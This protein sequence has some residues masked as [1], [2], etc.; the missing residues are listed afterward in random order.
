MKPVKRSVLAIS[1]IALALLAQHYLAERIYVVDAILLYAVAAYLTVRAFAGTEAIKESESVSPSIEASWPQR[2][3]TALGIACLL[4]VLSLIWLRSPAPPSWGALLWLASLVSFVLA[5][6][7]QTGT[8]TVEEQEALPWQELVVLGFVVL[9]GFL[10]RFYNL[11]FLP[12]SLHG[13]EA[14]TG[15]QAIE[16]MEGRVNDLFATGWYDL[17]MLGFAAYSVSMRVLGV[18]VFGLRMASV[19]FGTLSL[20]PF[21]FLVRS[22]FRK[23]TAVIS[24]ILLAVSH[25]YVH[26]SRLGIN[27]IQT[28]FFELL[29]FY[30]L[31]RALR[32]RKGSDFVWGGFAV[33]F[34][35]YTYYA[36]RLVP[37][38]ILMFLAYRALREKGFLRSN[39]RGIAL[40]AAAAVFAFAPLGLYFVDHGRQFASRM[41]GVFIFTA[42]NLD[43]FF[44]A[45]HTR[46]PLR[47]LWIQIVQTL[48]VF[49]YR[50]DTSGQYGFQEPILDP[51]TSAFFIL[52][53]AYSLSQWRRW[54]HFFLN[55]W[56]W[57]T[58]VTG[59]ILTTDAPFTPRLV[60]MVPVLFIFA[61]LALDR[62]REQLSQAFRP[63][64]KRYFA[65][66]TALALL[67][68][69]Y[70]NGDAYLNRYIGKQKPMSASTELARYIR[71]LGPE[72]RTYLLGAPYL[73]FGF[74]A[75]RFIARG[76]EGVDVHN[77]ADEVPIRSGVG[78]EAV[79]ILLPSHLD[80]L[81][82]IRH[83]YPSGI[84]EEHRDVYNNL[85]FT[86][87]RVSSGG[88]RG[89]QGLVGRYYRG[90]N[91]QGKPQVIRWGSMVEAGLP[92]SSSGSS[93]SYPFSVIWEGTIF[94]PRYGR[95]AWG[96]DPG[97]HACLFLDGQ[98]LAEGEGSY[99]EG[100]A[101]LPAG[102]HAIEVWSVQR[103]ADDRIALY[104][105]SPYGEKE[106]VP[107]HVLFSA[108]EIYG[109]LGS[110][111]GKGGD[112]PFLK[113]LDPIIA[114][115]SLG[116]PGSSFSVEWEGCIRIP[117]SGTYT[118]ET[119][120]WD[121]SRVYLDGQL[122]VDNEHQGRDVRA[123]GSI[124][125]DQGQ[126]DLRV[127]GE[128]LSG[129]RL[130]ELRW[131]PPG[132]GLQL[133]PSKVLI[134]PDI[135][136]GSASTVTRPPV[137]DRSE[138]LSLP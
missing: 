37:L 78:K 92:S 21:Y 31:L 73:Y 89:R 22:L 7:G 39:Y 81:S 68:I 101:M 15:L 34:G 55:L 2:T 87:Y 19:I 104:W 27:Y 83:Y 32:F 16:I 57:V 113:R 38:L 35:L 103:T 29:A 24:T 41:G 126:H 50:G 110:Y 123:S 111:Y 61:G 82:F 105:A 9:V 79:F 58:I 59:N 84:L 67:L 138:C 51:F 3:W 137:Q 135:C 125:L 134:P 116:K 45:Y 127:Q 76:S 17:P 128:F 63:G 69:A 1:A 86:S 4:L 80:A 56:F 88:I 40:M 112:L 47:V 97:T 72:Y 100:E 119:Y 96:L 13:D 118:F 66:V 102:P 49:N 14:E 114:F 95:Y 117:Q 122:V 6:I 106:I 5:F 20:L 42:S 77:V 94:L 44:Y 121:S 98:L 43:H 52:G 28:P 120:S 136:W 99:V 53:L 107:R 10:L 64:G 65:L 8:E 48:S 124:D 11:E 75:I 85:M 23:Q 54:E 91:W 25:W 12:P 18:G 130:L 93:L 129:W 132:E 108:S 30:F 36:S 74:G 131:A 115:R 62:T 33:G 90:E 71:S 70:T 46:D 60:G 133:V 26:F 109:L